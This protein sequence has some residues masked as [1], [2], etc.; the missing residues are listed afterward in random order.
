[1]KSIICIII[2][3][4]YN[5]TGVKPL[6]VEKV[7]LGKFS[8]VIYKENK[9]IHD[10]NMVAYYFVLYKAGSEKIQCSS[11]MI[12]K[13]NDTTFIA[14]N[15][16]LEGNKI[17]FIERYYYNRNLFSADSIKKIFS[18]NK[19]GTLILK[20]VVKYKDGSATRTKY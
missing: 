11:F 7:T 13:R 14:G 10:D 4:I 17:E 19:Y 6:L 8:Y 9:H 5:L 16:I 3:F 2:L 18:P 15:Y 20:E 12:A 1:M